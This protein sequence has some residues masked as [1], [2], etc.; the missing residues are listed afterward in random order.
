MMSS[1][2]KEIKG[3]CDQCIYGCSYTSDGNLTR[4]CQGVYPSSIEEAHKRI[5][6]AMETGSCKIHEEEGYEKWLEMK[7]SGLGPCDYFVNTPPERKYRI[8]KSYS[9]KPVY[10]CESGNPHCGDGNKLG[11]YWKVPGC[12]SQMRLDDPTRMANPSILRGAFEAAGIDTSNIE[13]LK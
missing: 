6:E 9:D 5:V 3:V 2:I 11:C 10:A 1:K 13:Y 12:T 4:I 7:E 8:N